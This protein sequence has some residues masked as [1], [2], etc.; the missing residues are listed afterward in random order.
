VHYPAPT[1]SPAV[2][3]FVALNWR[4]RFTVTATIAMALLVVP[5]SAGASSGVT[6]TPV[7]PHL[8]RLLDE[9]NMK[10]E[11]VCANG[12]DGFDFATLAAEAVQGFRGAHMKS[13]PWNRLPQDEVIFECYNG[14]THKGFF[15]D[16]KGQRS[17]APPIPRATHCQQ[18][19]RGTACDIPYPGWVVPRNH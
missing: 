14:L 1:R 19:T 9:A 7:S 11:S 15:T 12:H 8:L 2:A 16:Q 13:S 18:T 17:L 3:L 5:G 4:R 6:S 10:A